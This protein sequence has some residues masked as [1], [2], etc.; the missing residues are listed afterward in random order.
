MTPHII[1][2]QLFDDA[3]APVE[4]EW[5]IAYA[6]C[7]ERFA[8]REKSVEAIWLW[9]GDVAF[10]V[11]RFRT[12]RV[13]GES[14]TFDAYREAERKFGPLLDMEAVL[15]KCAEDWPGDGDVTWEEREVA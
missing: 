6:P 12:E 2:R 8:I 5:E 3:E 11:E 10:R 4:I 1:F 7:G 15:E 9:L 14:I 13:N